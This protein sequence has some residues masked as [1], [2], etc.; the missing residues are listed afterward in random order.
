MRTDS[1][2]ILAVLF[3]LLLFGV[4]YN[5]LISWAGRR[6]YLEGLIWL[7]V[8]V[9]VTITLAGLALL[10]PWETVLLVAAGFACSGAPMAAGAVARY[11][12]AREQA[13]AAIRDEAGR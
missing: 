2:S 7:A 6:G 10:I 3:G 5:G 9:G 8:V 12:Q 11:V 13:Q 1:G 4:G